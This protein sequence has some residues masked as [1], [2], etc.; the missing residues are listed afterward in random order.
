ME[1]TVSKIESEYKYKGRIKETAE[2]VRRCR[3]ANWLEYKV[4]R[5]SGT[6]NGARGEVRSKTRVIV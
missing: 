6:A 4:Q 1:D 2:E 3:G 5:V